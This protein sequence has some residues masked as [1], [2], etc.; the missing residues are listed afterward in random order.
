MHHHCCSRHIT[1]TFNRFEFCSSYN[2]VWKFERDACMNVKKSLTGQITEESTLHF[3]ADNVN[4]NTCMLNGNNTLHGIEIITAVTEGK[5]T[6]TDIQQKLVSNRLVKIN[7][8]HYSQTCSND[9]LSLTPTCLRR[10]MLNRSKQI[11]IQLLLYK[12]TTC[13]TWPATTFFSPQNEK[14]PV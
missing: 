10:P 2:E 7:V 4:H 3:V 11:A 8:L 5:F 1:D 6:Q 9:H 13:L 12:M 14:N